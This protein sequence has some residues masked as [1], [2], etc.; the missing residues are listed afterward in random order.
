MVADSAQEP[1]NTLTPRPPGQRLAVALLV[2][3]V[4]AV[5]WVTLRPDPGAEWAAQASPP[6][7]IACGEAGLADLLLNVVLFVP[8]GIALHRLRW[9][10]WAAVAAGL[11]LSG[12]IEA[13]QG[14][15][16]VGRD[17]T[18]GD[19]LA[20]TAGT[21]IGFGLMAWWGRRRGDS[22]VAP[23]TALLAFAA[24]LVICGWL[25]EPRLSG[26]EPW[27]TRVPGEF[28]GRPLYPGAVL[29]WALSGDLPLPLPVTQLGDTVPSMQV[30]FEWGDVESAPVFRVENARGHALAALGASREQVA[31]SL[32]VRG[33]A[34]RL[35]TPSWRVPVSTTPGDTM[36]VRMRSVRDA[37][38]IEAA[39]RAGTARHVA[40]V[41]PQ[42]GWLLLNPFAPGWTGPAWLAYA[43]LW[44]GGW[45]AVLGLAAAGAR[46]RGWWLAAAA[47]TLIGITAAAGA[48]VSW[49]ELAALAGGWWA[50]ISAGRLRPRPGEA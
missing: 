22:R 29:R 7:C 16:L 12:C 36:T 50:G 1:F 5:A 33:S 42:H 26:P 48:V 31:V 41:G 17:A 9:A 49:I 27:R 15:V 2:S 8:L 47:V 13:T 38:T 32:A 44:L 35:R 40:R 20:N 43:V 14:V 45:G 24:M 21:G 19:L 11:A 46:H 37:I 6:W 4:L 28:E 18:L 10:G 23:A 34:W 30:V 25:L 3:W 39:T